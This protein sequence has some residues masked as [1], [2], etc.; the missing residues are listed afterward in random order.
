[1]KRYAGKVALITGAGRGIG[2][3][4]A[5]RL[6]AEGTS[7][8]ILDATAPAAEEAAAAI[9]RTGAGGDRAR[10][11]HHGPCR[12]RRRAREDPRGLRARSTC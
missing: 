12:R 7:V 6:A 11:R 2:R 4:S 1:M 10:G 3:A 8:A 9:G 5:L